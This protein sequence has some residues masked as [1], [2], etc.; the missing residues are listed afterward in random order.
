MHWY[1]WLRDRLVLELRSVE[2][3]APTLCEG[4][5]AA[6]LAAHVYLR[7][8]R[9]WRATSSGVSTLAAAS[10]DPASYARL[11]DE[12]AQPPG[13]LSPHSW[14][15]DAIDLAELFIHG[16]DVRRGAGRPAERD[17]PEGLV[18]ALRDRIGFFARLTYRRSPVG[19]LLVD[20]DGRRFV[21][22]RARSGQGSVAVRGRVEELVLHASGRGRASDVA[23][24]GSDDDVA[25]FVSAV[26]G[27]QGR[28]DDPGP[29]DDGP[30]GDRSP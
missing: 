17:L 20:P 10:A 22:R 19:V 11:V 6:H 3:S 4:W 15:G 8:H 23:L 12:V 26:P 25:A 1:P 30:Q 5:T 16:E 24:H 7:E 18:A 14:A 29:A 27:A 21:A 13:R 9:P 28:A 2:P